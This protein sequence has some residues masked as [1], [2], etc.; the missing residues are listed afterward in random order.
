MAEQPEKQPEKQSAAASQK[1]GSR[2]R[3]F[4]AGG[5]VAAVLLALTGGWLYRHFLVPPP[6][7]AVTASAE[8]ALLNLRDVMAA[9]PRYAELQQLHE[10]E[11]SLRLSLEAVA[12]LEPP[13]LT[14]ESPEVESKPFDDSVWQK[15]AQ[16]VIGE[17]VALAREQEQLREKYGKQP[18][19]E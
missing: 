14:V 7:A 9:H 17:R 10:E 2:R 3:R 6:P 4:I 16:A 18:E 11:K 12:D 1:R 15:N 13:E 8:A 19:E 5:L